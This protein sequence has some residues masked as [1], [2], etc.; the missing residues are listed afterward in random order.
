MVV[1][2]IAWGV[3]T[4][5]GRSAPSL[6]EAT[7]GN[8][9]RTTPAVAVMMLVALDHA[10]VTTR[11]LLLAVLSGAVASGIGYA[12][13]YMALSSL[14]ATRAALVQLSVPLLAAVG[15]VIVLSE[16]ISPQ[17]LVA[18]ILILGESD[19]LLLAR[20]RRNRTSGERPTVSQLF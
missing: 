11:G 18:S 2:G 3:Y 13:W 12:V 19:S 14:T 20:L 17:L 8:F 9:I 15:G 7:T 1:A 10:T 16:V 4:L 5:R 6:L